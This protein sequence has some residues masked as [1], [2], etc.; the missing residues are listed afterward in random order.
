MRYAIF[1]LPAAFLNGC[2]IY[3][4]TC[5][6][7]DRA[8][9]WDETSGNNSENQDTA[10]LGGSDS[11]DTAE[12]ATPAPAFALDPNE[13]SPGETVIASLTAE[14]FDMTTVTSVEAF[15]AGQV[16]AAAFRPDEILLTVQVDPAATE[17]DSL[18]LLLHVGEDAVYANDVLTVHLGDEANASGS[19]GDD[20]SSSS[21][22]GSGSGSGDGTEDSGSGNGAGC[23]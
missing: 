4:S 15:G 14:N 18:D 9:S 3:D 19:G 11:G 5:G 8:C 22:G 13:A 12:N 1:L 6:H 2:I 7:K 16:L 17:G 10:G 20:G 23:G 21:S